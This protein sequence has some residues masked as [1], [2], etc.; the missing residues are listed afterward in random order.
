[1]HRG[2][3]VY[4]FAYPQCDGDGYNWY[5]LAEYVGI[6]SMRNAVVGEHIVL[7]KAVLRQRGNL[8]M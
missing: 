4:Q 7:V 1:M 8:A 5:E 6:I 2:R 3:T